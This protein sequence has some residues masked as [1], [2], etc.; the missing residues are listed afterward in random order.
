MTKIAPQH[1][2]SMI[3][4]LIAIVYSA[5]LA[6]YTLFINRKTRVFGA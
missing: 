4:Y 3:L 5:L 6:I 1:R 2:L